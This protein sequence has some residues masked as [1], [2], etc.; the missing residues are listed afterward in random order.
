MT[1][2]QVELQIRVVALFKNV[3]T[4]KLVSETAEK[5]ARLAALIQERIIL[6]AEGR[7]YD[8]VARKIDETRANK[9]MLTQPLI[10]L[11]AA[12]DSLTDNRNRLLE[13]IDGDIAVLNVR[14]KLQETA[15]HRC[16]AFASSSSSSSSS[17]TAA[18]M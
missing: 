11:V 1:I 18:G 14:R 5:D 10:D 7:N 15:V 4:M 6:T 9:T 16:V 17:V 3:V 8:A 2:L 12:C 13:Y